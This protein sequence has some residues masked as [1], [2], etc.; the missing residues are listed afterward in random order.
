MAKVKRRKTNRSPAPAGPVARVSPIKPG[1]RGAR[2]WTTAQIRAA[3]YTRKG[4]IRL[5]LTCLLAVTFLMFIGLWLGG[6]LPDVDRS[7]REFVKSRL[8]AMGFVVKRVDIKGEGRLP[9][10]EIRAALNIQ[11]GQYIFDVDMKS[12]QARVEDLN[13]VDHAIVRRLWPDRIVVQIIERRPYALW[14]NQG[15]LKVV[16]VSGK[17]IENADISVYT[18]LPLI[19]GEG[20][21]REAETILTLLQSYPDISQRVS[22]L[23]YM[24]GTRW[25]LQMHGGDMWVKLPAQA[26][27]SA[28]RRLEIMQ[29]DK[30]ILDR[31]IA[32]IDLRIADRISFLP[33]RQKKA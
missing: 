31:Q 16:D 8:T 28:L 1:L 21:P 17:P 26:P 22:A 7:S 6:F 19:V 14:Q 27:E 12:V 9:E 5:A 20:A 13:W 11:D 4:F 25:N 29:T 30:A 32:E 15:A 24:N 10:T 33:T 3:R 23:V 2:N 18:E